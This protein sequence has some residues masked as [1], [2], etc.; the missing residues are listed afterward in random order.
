MDDLGQDEVA[1]VRVLKFLARREP[2][3]QSIGCF[4]HGGVALHLE[5]RKPG[6]FA[7]DSRGVR[8]Q[9]PDRDFPPCLR[10]ALQIIGDLVVQVQLAIF[11]QQQ[12]AGGEEL[13][14]HRSDLID[15]LGPRGDVELDVGQAVALRRTIVPSLTTAMDKPGMSLPFDLGCE[16]I[17]NF[18][19]GKRMGGDNQ[20]HQDQWQSE[21]ESRS[22]HGETPGRKVA[23]Q[24]MRSGASLPLKNSRI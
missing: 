17:V 1:D 18:V 21:R 24:A 5:R 20:D 2:Q 15:R 6:R 7:R 9:V 4:D 22:V 13:L 12:D 8:Q 16:V 19:R 11:H 23:R 3:R 14:A 10:R